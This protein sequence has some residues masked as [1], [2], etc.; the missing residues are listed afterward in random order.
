M[1][2]L[3]IFTRFI[4]L[5]LLEPNAIHFYKVFLYYCSQPFNVNA[6]HF[7]KVILLYFYRH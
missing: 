7:Y 1:G 5:L 6:I 3:Y 4:L 2:K